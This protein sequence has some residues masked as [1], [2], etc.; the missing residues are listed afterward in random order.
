MTSIHQR[1]INLVA[2]RMRSI[3]NRLMKAT[4]AA[5]LCDIEIDIRGDKA[6]NLS[7]WFGT[8]MLVLLLIGL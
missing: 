6:D 5:R 1:R 4:I 2:L 3:P 7:D 8:L